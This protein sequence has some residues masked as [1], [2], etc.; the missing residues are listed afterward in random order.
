MLRSFTLPVAA[1]QHR[2]T[3]GLTGSVDDAAAHQADLLAEH[4]HRA[5][6]DAGRNCRGIDRA[7]HVGLAVCT[8]VEEH[9]AFALDD[10]TGFDTAARLEH[11]AGQRA[12]RRDAHQHEPAFGLDRTAVFRQRTECR[13]VHAHAQQSA[14]ADIERHA[15]TRRERHRS[16]RRANGAVVSDHLAEQGHITLR[17]GVDR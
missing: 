17:R 4:G 14:A 9:P 10:G 8:T 2:A 6:F 13:R 7:G 16:L 12:R 15:L 5:A 3:A 11:H 1:D